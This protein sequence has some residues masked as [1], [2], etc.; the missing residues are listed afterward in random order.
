MFICGNPIIRP[1]FA[2]FSRRSRL[3]SK[4]KLTSLKRSNSWVNKTKPNSH[5]RT[6]LNWVWMSSFFNVANSLNEIDVSELMM[7][8][9]IFI[10]LYC[11]HWRQFAFRW[12]NTKDRVNYNGEDSQFNISQIIRDNNNIL[13][14]YVFFFK[15]VRQIRI[16]R[17]SEYLVEYLCTI[18]NLI[19]SVYRSN[20]FFR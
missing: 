12:K 6:L 14:L 8:I 15:S 13:I 16:I 2:S 3:P 5:L 4:S 19:V 10:C 1:I 11:E 20:I 17:G 18:H 7:R 9:A